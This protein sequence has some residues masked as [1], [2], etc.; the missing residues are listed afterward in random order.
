MLDIGLVSV[1]LGLS[2]FKPFDIQ[3]FILSNKGGIAEQFVGQQL[4][5]AQSIY[6]EPQ[7]YYW[8]KT[9]GGQAELD[10]IIQHGDKI[11]QVEI[12]AGASG[13]MKSLHQF[14]YEKK[15]DIAVRFN[16][17]RTDRT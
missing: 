1:Q 8:Q 16:A 5:A 13:T 11:I 9:G 15:L 3:N 2:S 12:K 7:L 17:N 10:Y 4:R 6:S 14:M